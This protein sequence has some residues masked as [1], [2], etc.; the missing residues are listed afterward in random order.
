MH[1]GESWRESEVRRFVHAYPRLALFSGALLFA[2]FSTA[3]I[4]LQSPNFLAGYDF[5]RMHYFYRAFYRN[6][7]LAGRLPLWNP[8]VGLGRPFLSDIEAQTFYPPNLLVLPFGVRIGAALLLI[9]H[10]AI[11]ICGG[12]CLA[13]KLGA[14]TVPGFLAGV[15][16]ALASPFTA[17]LA[18]GMV[19]VYFLLCW[20][21]ALLWLGACLQDSWSRRDAARF[22][23]VACM[24]I[25]SGN[26][27]ILFVE[28][29]GLFV[30]LIC[31]ADWGVALAGWRV[32]L[33]NHAGIAAA[34]LLGAGLACVQLLPFAELVSQGNRPIH[35]AQFAVAN[36]IPPASWL[37]L[38]FPTS[39][40]FGPNWEYDL[41]CGLLPLFAAIGGVVFWRDRN[42]RGLLGLGLAGALLG[43][44]DRA[45]FLSWVVQVV[46]GAGA[47]R[48]PSRYGILFAT[49]LIGLAAVS[50]TRR[51]AR[52]SL[53][54]LACFGICASFIVWLRPYVIG[55]HGSAGDYY[56][57]HLGVLGIAAVLMALWRYRPLWPRFGMAAACAM[58]AFC[59][60]DWLWAIHLEAPVYSMYGFRTNEESVRTELERNGLLVPGA[61]PPR[62]LFDPSDLCE[63]AGMTGGFSTINSYVNPALMRV[64]SYLHV[65]SGVPAS[66][67]DFIRLPR[68][69]DDSADRMK[70]INLTAALDH[71]TRRLVIQEPSDPRVYMVFD[72]E[73]VQDWRAAEQRMGDGHELRRKA[74]IEAG[75]APEF[76]PTPGIHAASAV[77]TH[78]EPESIDVSTHSDATGILVLD[79]A[80]YPGWRATI[81]QTPVNVFPVNGWMRGVVVP[82][83]DHEI[84]FTYHSRFLQLG[85]GVSLVSALILAALVLC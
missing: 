45:P 43:V 42:M 9:L 37:S 59:T 65:A 2:T 81:A 25:L 30:F 3:W 36:G 19:P 5:Q 40:R 21:P 24:A 80:W 64:W 79:E 57:I 26:P 47:L 83:G 74:L 13:R 10:Q 71:Q 52:P 39:V 72:A 70:S 50:I 6:A 82:P 23:A 16:M 46:P 31:R 22:A 14:Q 18:T 62:I 67:S 49:A 58:A 84:K 7:L 29:L 8:Y 69:I 41:Y 11:A 68:A 33:R 4:I 56:A 55:T 78:F 1:D 61:V 73:V 28:F 20:W 34:A 35:S 66:T 12:A 85:S 54:I 17:R 27:P 44:G 51:P 60:C 15:G 77:I 75:Y 76:T 53:P 38:F 48:F 32:Q 63:N